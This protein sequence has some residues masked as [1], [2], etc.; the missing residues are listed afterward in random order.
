MVSIADLAETFGTSEMTIRRDLDGLEPRGI[1]Q[2]VHGGAI[3]VT[4]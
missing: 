3:A 1:S 2:R 4:P